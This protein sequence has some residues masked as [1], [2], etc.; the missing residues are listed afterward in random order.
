MNGIEG[1][2]G[3]DRQETVDLAW[4]D[5]VDPEIEQ[6][7]LAIRQGEGSWR[8]TSARRQTRTDRKPRPPRTRP[9][10]EVADPEGFEPSTAGLEIRCPIRARRRVQ[11]GHRGAS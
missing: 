9:D 7:L 2:S 5:S 1:E 6:R 8:V 4:L 10:G 3:M 11:L